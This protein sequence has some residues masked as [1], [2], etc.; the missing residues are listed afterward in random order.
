MA[1]DYTIR[2]SRDNT[3]NGQLIYDGS[4]KHVCNCWWDPPDKIPAGT[5]PGCSATFMSKATNSKGTKR[6]AIFIPGVPGRTGIFLHYWPGTNLKVWS[7]GCIL[8]M[9]QDILLIWND[10]TPHDGRNVTVTVSDLAP[11]PFDMRNCTPGRPGH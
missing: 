4:F 6:E 8:L 10:I 2:V 9:E 1:N 5:Y 11:I 3:D 7:D